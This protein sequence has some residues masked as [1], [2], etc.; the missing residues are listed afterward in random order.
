[1]ANIV[2]DLVQKKL[3]SPP[4][5][6][7]MNCHYLTMMGSVA[8]GV[9]SDTSDMDIY[10]WCIPSKEILFPHLAGE[11]F[12]FGTQK[13][14]FNQW[15][16]HHIKDPCAMQGKGRDYDLT[17]YNIVDYFQLL[18]QNNPNMVDSIF[19]PDNCV[20]HI[21]RIGTMVREKR[22][23]FLHKKCWQTYKSYSYAQMK[24]IRNKELIPE[25]KKILDFERQHEIPKETTFAEVV[26]EMQRRGLHTS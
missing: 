22:K 18:M 24:K 26:L 7:P 21:T 12:G 4:P 1:M 6:L 5:W 2:D 10:G 11:I 23:L 25:V 9:S 3:A 20:L 17:V 16:Q 13:K 14:R 19:T 8:Y 15:Q